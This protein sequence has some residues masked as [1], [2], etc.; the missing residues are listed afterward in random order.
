MTDNDNTLPQIDLSATVSKFFAEQ[1][2]YQQQMEALRPANKQALFDALAEA[3]ID[4]VTVTFDGSGDSGQ[5][6]DVT[7]QCG[8]AVVGLPSGEITISTMSWGSGAV[9][10]S[11]M[12]V[13]AAVEQLSYDFLSETHGGWENNDGAFGEFTFD[14]A[15]RRISLDYNDRYTAVESYSHEF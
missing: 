11:A 9:T 6:E 4:L 5:I 13:A 10:T 14:V 2:T 7:A 15:E 1:A 3:G 8:E 12:T